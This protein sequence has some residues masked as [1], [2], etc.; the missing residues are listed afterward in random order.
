MKPLRRE[1]VRRQVRGERCATDIYVSIDLILR[2]E[3]RATVKHAARVITAA[4]A[5]GRVSHEK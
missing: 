1:R 5:A 4:A 2:W 3:D